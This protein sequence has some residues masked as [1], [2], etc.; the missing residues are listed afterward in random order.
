MKPTIC[1]VLV[2]CLAGFLGQ[3]CTDKDRDSTIEYVPV[4]P[5]APG[6]LLDKN[7]IEYHHTIHPGSDPEECKFCHGDMTQETTLSSSILAFHDQKH[8]N[9]STWSCVHCHDGPIDL[10][11]KS[12]RLLRKTVD[13]ETTCYQC[14]GPAGPNTQLYQ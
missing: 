14:H 6:S 1:V 13:V 12:H 5:P 11:D 2:A 10:V 4:N 8:T 9:L 7:V 3:G